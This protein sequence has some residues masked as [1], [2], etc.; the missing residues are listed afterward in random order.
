M[1]F[2]QVLSENFSVCLWCIIGDFLSKRGQAAPGALPYEKASRDSF[3]SCPLSVWPLEPE[4]RLGPEVLPSLEVK[5]WPS[6][7]PLGK[8][9]DGE[10]AVGVGREGQGSDEG[11]ETPR[12]TVGTPN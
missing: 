5:A 12:H 1:V 9:G 2:S 6:R 7:V 8:Q 10:E 3:P 11:G 4:D